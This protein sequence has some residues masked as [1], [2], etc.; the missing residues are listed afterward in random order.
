MEVVERRDGVHPLSLDRD[1]G[2]GN[3]ALQRSFTLAVRNEGLVSE[4]HAAMAQMG[5]KPAGH[6]KHVLDAQ[7][8]YAESPHERVAEHALADAFAAF[9]DQRYAGRRR[10]V[11]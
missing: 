8:V 4:E 1:R 10:R 3:K 11:L 9:E 7:A 6:V 2:L 5:I